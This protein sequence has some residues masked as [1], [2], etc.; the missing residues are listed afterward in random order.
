MACRRQRGVILYKLGPKSTEFDNL[1]LSLRL[2]TRYHNHVH[3]HPLLV[4]HDT[5]LL[6]SVKSRI[7]NATRFSGDGGAQMEFV[8]LHNEV[9]SWLPAAN[10]PATVLGFSVRNDVDKGVVTLGA[11]RHIADGAA[12]FLRG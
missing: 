11:E 4:A 12:K 6:E 3:R 7:H 9:P 1:L 8:R 2:L 5:A 10:V